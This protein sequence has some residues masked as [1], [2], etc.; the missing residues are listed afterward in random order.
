MRTYSSV[1]RSGVTVLATCIAGLSLDSDYLNGPEPDGCPAV[2]DLA[3]GIVAPTP[4]GVVGSPRTGVV[5]AADHAGSVAERPC[6]TEL[7]VVVVAPTP[8]RSADGCGVGHLA[9][10]VLSV[11]VA[12]PSWPLSCRPNTRPSGHHTR[13]RPAGTGSRRWGWCCRWWWRFRVVHRRCRP[14]TTPPSRHLGPAANLICRFMW[15]G[16]CSSS[17]RASRVW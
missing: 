11:V 8:G 14:N 16:W 15:G 17:R 13:V 1:T 6:P 2:S 4:D 5:A 12:F 7:A 10:V 9:G 3:L